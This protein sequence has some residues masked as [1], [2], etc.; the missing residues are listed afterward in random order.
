MNDRN[1]QTEFNDSFSLIAT[2]RALIYQ[3]FAD[4]L[5]IE[6]SA[7]DLAH[8]Q[9]PAAAQLWQHFAHC[10]LAQESQQMQQ[11]LSEALSLPDSHLELAAD[12]AAAFLLAADYCATPYASWYVE[13][14]KKFYGD[15]EK[16]MREF[17]KQQQL[18]IHSDFKE[19]ADHLAVFLSV[20]AHWLQTEQREAAQAAAEQAQFLEQALLNWLPLWQ[21][22][23][24]QLRL[25]TAVYPALAKLLLAFVQA[26][27]AYLRGE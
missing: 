13:A 10:G 25:K 23:C 12:F 18:Q 14:D 20:F 17:L 1:L 21:A 22:R 16:R 15:A 26:D 4:W 7:A 27:S 6:R 24:Q 11:A 5:A 3:W 19:P 8:Y 2:Q 9:S